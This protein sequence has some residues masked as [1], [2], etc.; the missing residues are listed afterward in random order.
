MTTFTQGLI[1]TTFA[2]AGA[3]AVPSRIPARP[4]RPHPP[5]SGEEHGKRCAS[6]T[7]GDACRLPDAEN[8][9]EFLE[10]AMDLFPLARRVLT[11]YADNG[12][13]LRPRGGRRA[14]AQPCTARPRGCGPSWWSAEQPA[15][16]VEQLY[17]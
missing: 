4:G 1:M 7:C 2:L 13:A 10:A 14:W 8:G 12:A 17:R 5:G 11:A 3:G 16:G 6:S 15:G 9:V